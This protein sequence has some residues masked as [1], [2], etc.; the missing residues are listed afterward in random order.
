MWFDLS[1]LRWCLVGS[2]RGFVSGSRG[3]VSGDGGNIR[4]LVMMAVVVFPIV[5]AISVVRVSPL[6]L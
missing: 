2:S 5:L 6:N 1:V 3:R 4:G